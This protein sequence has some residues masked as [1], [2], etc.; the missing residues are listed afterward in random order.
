MPGTTLAGLNAA[1]SR[2]KAD[3]AGVTGM[4]QRAE[5][6]GRPANGEQLLGIGACSGRAGRGKLEIESSIMA[7]AAALT[8]ACCVGMAGVEGFFDIDHAYFLALERGIERSNHVT[9][10]ASRRL[11]VATLAGRSNAA[12]A[13]GVPSSVERAMSRIHDRNGKFGSYRGC[14]R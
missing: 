5:K 8:P 2:G 3:L 7:A 4:A 11:R 9:C 1:C 6:T 14:P 13:S 10:K 12:S